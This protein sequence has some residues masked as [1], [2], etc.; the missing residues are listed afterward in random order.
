MLCLRESLPISSRDA[1][2]LW[3][4]GTMDKFTLARDLVVAYVMDT[5]K[6]ANYGVI[7]KKVTE[8]LRAIIQDAC[9][10]AAGKE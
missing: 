10:K 1:A 6:D 9:D 5:Y 8:D 2:V 7:Q 3:E 4:I